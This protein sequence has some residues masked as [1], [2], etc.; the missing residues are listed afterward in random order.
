MY[1]PKKE[2]NS[3]NIKSTNIW[4]YQTVCNSNRRPW[5]KNANRMKKAKMVQKQEKSS[6][7]CSH[8]LNEEVISLV[9]CEW[10]ILKYSL[11]IQ[12]KGQKITFNSSMVQCWA[13][14]LFL[15]MFS[16]SWASLRKISFTETTG[17]VNI[18]SIFPDSL[19]T[20]VMMWSG[21]EEALSRS[22]SYLNSCTVFSDG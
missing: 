1:F 7:S 17:T 12:V 5:L 14:L 11:M 6:S 16:C 19:I 20:F 3:P 18:W 21:D 15:H 4:P 10:L 8:D 9:E 2:S 22:F 13:P